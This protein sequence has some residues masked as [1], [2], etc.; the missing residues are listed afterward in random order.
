MH[1]MQHI[2]LDF[3][4]QHILT[5]L[6]LHLTVGNEHTASGQESKDAALEQLKL[7]LGEIDTHSE[8]TPNMFDG[9][10]VNFLCVH[11]SMDVA[12]TPFSLASA[13][14]KCQVHNAPQSKKMTTQ[15]C[16]MVFY[17]GVPAL[18]VPRSINSYLVRTSPFFCGK[19]ADAE[20]VNAPW[21]GCAIIEVLAAFGGV[22]SNAA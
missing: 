14:M 7:L 1:P 8:D 5:E 12:N 6:H 3:D 13:Q 2:A 20:I 10:N 16:V 18:M 15:E 17:D 4:L 9:L 22:D 11:N 19:G 21:V